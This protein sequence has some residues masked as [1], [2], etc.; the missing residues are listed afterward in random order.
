MTTTD[1]APRDL[2]IAVELYQ[3]HGN[4]RA[5]RRNYRPDL[6]QLRPARFEGLTDEQLDR[7]V[8]LRWRAPEGSPAWEHSLELCA[9]RARRRGHHGP[10]DLAYFQLGTVELTERHT[11]TDRAYERPQDWAEKIA[12]PQTVPLWSNGYYLR[13]SFTARHG[14]HNLY[15]ATDPTTYTVRPYAYQLNELAAILPASAELRI[16]AAAVAAVGTRHHTPPREREP[17][18]GQA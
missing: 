9:E 14:R 7:E 17:R 1:H 6:T 18:I 13:V 12:E 8:S 3:P 10:G 4:E 11:F 5:R 16:D 2:T 15:H